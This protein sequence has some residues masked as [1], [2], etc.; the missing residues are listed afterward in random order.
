MI[1]KVV[2]RIGRKRVRHASMIAS[3]SGMPVARSV[4]A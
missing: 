3:R 1:A 2:I 4:L